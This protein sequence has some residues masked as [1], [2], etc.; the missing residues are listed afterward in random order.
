[1]K[2]RARGGIFQDVDDGSIWKCTDSKRIK[3]GSYILTLERDDG[4]IVT[5]TGMEM[6]SDYRRL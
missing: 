2:K 4:A 5:I 1:M 6:M 3:T